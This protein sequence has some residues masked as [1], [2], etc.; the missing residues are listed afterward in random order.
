MFSPVLQIII[1]FFLSAFVVIIVT[2]IAENYGTKA[3]GILGT[4]PSTIIIAFVFIALSEDLVF[5]SNAASVVPAE[6]GINVIFLFIFAI[7]VKR[8]VVLAFVRGFEQ[9]HSECEEDH[10]IQL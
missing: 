7:L 5:A 9:V 1:P 6:L 4:L 2:Y 8:S 3:G 10:K